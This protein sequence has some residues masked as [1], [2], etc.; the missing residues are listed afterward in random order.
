MK[1]LYE[2]TCFLGCTCWCIH[3][4]TH[5]IPY[6]FKSFLFSINI[7]LFPGFCYNSQREHSC[8]CLRLQ[9]QNSLSVGGLYNF[10]W[11]IRLY[12]T[13]QCQIVFQSSCANSHIHQEFP[14]HQILASSRYH[15]SFFFLVFTN[16]LDRK[17]HLTVRFLFL[18]LFLVCKNK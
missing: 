13:R 2:S 16:L 17:W 5:F 11:S 18:F 12:F 4:H 10:I 14:L 8:M 15:R 1:V 7:L 9:R 6:F 3:F